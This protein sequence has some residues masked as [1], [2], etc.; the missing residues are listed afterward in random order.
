MLIYQ[1]ILNTYSLHFLVLQNT[2]FGYERLF[3]R[4]VAFINYTDY[5]VYTVYTV[6]TA[7]TAY[8]TYTLYSG[9]TVF[10]VFTVYTTNI[11]FTSYRF[12]LFT[13][14]KL[15]TLFIQLT[16]L[17]LFQQLEANGQFCLDMIWISHRLLTTRAVIV[18]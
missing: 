7:Y 5:T 17:T 16:L 18:R 3:L 6:Y 4:K 11:A 2:C 13:H 9:R 1:F 15:L 10:I 14:L 12:T 8:T